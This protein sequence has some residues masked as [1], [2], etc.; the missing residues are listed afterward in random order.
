MRRFL[1]LA[2]LF[3]AVSCSKNLEES[4]SNTEIY[5]PRTGHKVLVLYATRADV[6]KSIVSAVKEQGESQAKDKYTILRF[7]GG[8][9]TAIRNIYPQQLLHE[10]LLREM[11][12]KPNTPLKR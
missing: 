1:I 11:A 7:P 8:Y 2:L 3:I 12:R 9:T 5:C 10:C 6:S 4:Q